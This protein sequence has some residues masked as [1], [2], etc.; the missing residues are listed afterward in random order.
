MAI[1]CHGYPPQNDPRQALV[2]ALSHRGTK[3]DELLST[4][5]PDRRWRRSTRLLST[6]AWAP[7]IG[8]RPS[9]HTTSACA[10][11]LT[12]WTRTLPALRRQFG[13]GGACI[14][15]LTAT[16]YSSAV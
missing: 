4:C 6:R 10:R 12:A 13:R 1:E 11:C 5:L 15:R 3:A 9:S 7:A 8:A 2:P 16:L 14:C